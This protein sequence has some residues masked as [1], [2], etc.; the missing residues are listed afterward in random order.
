MLFIYSLGFV[1]Q[2]FTIDYFEISLFQI[3]IFFRFPLRVRISAPQLYIINFVYE[4]NVTTAVFHM[5]YLQSQS[6]S[7]I[8]G[9]WQKFR[10]RQSSCRILGIFKFF[11]QFLWS[12]R[13]VGASYITV[14]CCF[15]FF[16]VV[17]CRLLWDETVIQHS[18]T[19][20]KVASCS[21]WRSSSILLVGWNTSLPSR[22]NWWKPLARIEVVIVTNILP[23]CL[24]TVFVP[25]THSN[26]NL[27]KRVCQL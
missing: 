4:S 14:V 11:S 21:S 27:Q 20:L 9:E 18:R 1:L 22:K 5:I 13:K 26:L 24:L 12:L 10:F 8:K 15:S 6:I 3:T 2:S 19:S 23:T 17:Q 7:K 25:F 16:S